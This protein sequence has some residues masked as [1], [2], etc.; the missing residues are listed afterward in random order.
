MGL[1]FGARHPSK[2][3]GYKSPKILMR[4]ATNIYRKVLKPGKG[5]IHK[6]EGVRGENL[7]K[8]YRMAAKER[9]PIHHTQD[10]VP[11]LNTQ[12]AQ[13]KVTKKISDTHTEMRKRLSPDKTTRFDLIEVANKAKQRA[14]KSKETAKEVNAA[15][16]EIDAYIDAEIGRHG[17]YVDASTFDSIKSGM[18]GV[19]YQHL[20]PT[21]KKNA[22]RIGRVI[23]ERIDTTYA[24]K[25]IRQLNQYT[26]DLSTLNDVLY[27]ADGTV[28]SRGAIGKYVGA[29]IGGMVGLAA[30]GLVPIPGLETV[31]GAA[32]GKL[33]SEHLASP[34]RRTKV[35]FGKMKK[36][37]GM[38][39][40]PI[41]DKMGR[42]IAERVEVSEVRE[43][44]RKF[45][46]GEVG[47]ATEGVIT[48]PLTRELPAPPKA[49]P[50]QKLLPPRGKYADTS[51]PVIH[52]QPQPKLPAPKQRPVFGQPKTPDVI[53]APS[54][55]PKI[56][57]K[58]VA[59]KG[60]TVFGKGFT[61]KIGAQKKGVIG[62]K[63]KLLR[64]TGKV[65]AGLAAGAVSGKAEAAQD[66]DMNKIYGIE[67]SNNPKALNKKSKAKGLGQITPIVLKEWNN[68]NKKKYEDTDLF[69]PKANKEISQWYMNKRIP[70][71][72]RHYKKPDTLKNRLIAYNAGI[73]YVVKSLP[74][75]RE[76]KN[77]LKKYGL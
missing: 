13:E 66:V 2:P 39:R 52:G 20:T 55:Q 60:A 51:G 36:A 71:M 61:A 77:Y 12:K 67:S 44:M 28:V 62:K 9:L 19:G 14:S 59:E 76:T 30:E 49:N 23:K 64:G 31:V 56:P 17:R 10:E 50:Y 38:M 4:E 21:A 22:R 53:Q 35:A 33:L 43:P 54:G 46:F 75:P 65:I 68:F 63:G 24:D 74:L 47:K 37:E 40:E 11:K 48:E 26:S 34:E 3:F 18:W 15:K 57:Y 16:V 72:L 7:N 25:K 42:K 73:N 69:N 45:A 29:G 27:D 8:Y 5:I 32:G 1:A 58:P 6:V 41:L 70:Q